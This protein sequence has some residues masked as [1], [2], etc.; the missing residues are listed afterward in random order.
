MKRR[1]MFRS[2]PWLLMPLKGAASKVRGKNSTLSEVSQLARSL[3]VESLGR[4]SPIPNPNERERREQAH[5]GEGRSS[6]VE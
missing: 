6:E 4:L 3:S 5:H 1:Q 2:W